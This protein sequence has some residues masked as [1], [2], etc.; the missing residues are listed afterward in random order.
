MKIVVYNPHWYDRTAGIHD[1]IVEFLR[2][3]RPAIQLSSTAEMLNWVKF[4]IRK[5]LPLLGWQYLFNENRVNNFDAWI[6]FAGSSR[7]ADV[8][9]PD[10]FSGLKIYHLMDYVYRPEITNEVLIKGNVDYLL[11]YAR[12]DQWCRMF[13]GVYP[14]FVNRVVPWPFGYSS[15]FKFQIPFDQRTNKC[16]VMGAVNLV[17]PAFEKKD[18]IA[19]YTEAYSGFTWAHPLRQMIRENIEELD[20]W[21]ESYLPGSGERTNL[22]YNSPEEL[23]RFTLFFNDESVMGFPPA[24]TFE[25]CA[26]G[27]VMVAK[28][29]P[30]YSDFGFINGVSCLMYKMDD[31]SEIKTALQQA[32]EHSELPMIQGQSLKHMEK[33]SHKALG[34]SLRN[35]FD[36]LQ[37]GQEDDAMTFFKAP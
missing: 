35:I 8:K 4:L 22:S 33:F 29:H 25:G 19:K 24:R 37:R 34:H 27:A 21:V 26:C 20:Q 11:G 16:S 6:C 1:Y 30:C 13:R 36:Y 15:R 31:P 10:R 17:S 32:V 7:S 18:V 3:Y 23:N 12:H 2:A 14:T 9:I 5:K 28:E